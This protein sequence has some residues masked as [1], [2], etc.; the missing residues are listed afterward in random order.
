MQLAP[1]SR[2]AEPDVT[3]ENIQSRCRGMLLMAISNKTGAPG[4]DHRQQERDGGRLRHAVRRH[5]RRL[6]ADQG[7][8][9]DAGVS[10]GALPQHAVGA[11]DPAARDRRG[12]RRRSCA[13][14]RRTRDSLPDYDV[15][16]PILEAFIEQD[17]SVAEIV[18]RGLR[19]RRCRARSSRWCGATNTSAGRR[20]RA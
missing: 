5:G 16:D 2:G 14:I 6:R 1:C 15:L 12:R 11:G 8:Q 17:L 18:E 13:R 20:R 4:A 9:Q 3:E 7:L 19:A 10:P